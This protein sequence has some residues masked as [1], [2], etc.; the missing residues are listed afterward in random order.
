MI[1]SL[2]GTVRA[3]KLDQAVLEVNGVGY[4][5]HITTKTSGCDSVSNE[6]I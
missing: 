3:L 6:A 2:F 4:L 5:V 1:A